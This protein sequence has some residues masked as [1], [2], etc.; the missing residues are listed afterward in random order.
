MFATGYVALIGRYGLVSCG[1]WEPLCIPTYGATEDDYQSFVRGWGARQAAIFVPFACAL[2][3]KDRNVLKA[4]FLCFIA[5]CVHDMFAI[6]VEGFQTDSLLSFGLVISNTCLATF[7]VYTI[8]K[9]VESSVE[10]FAVEEGS[11]DVRDSPTESK[12]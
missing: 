1:I 9:P 3:W 2:A 8:W 12:E 10:A 11:K 5:R 6:A 4:A 7:T